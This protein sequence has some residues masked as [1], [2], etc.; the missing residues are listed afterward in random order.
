MVEDLPPQSPREAGCLAASG[1]FITL[2][3]GASIILIIIGNFLTT[4]YRPFAESEEITLRFLDAARSGNHSEMRSYLS[5]RGNHQLSDESLT[6]ISNFIQSNV[7]DVVRLSRTEEEIFIDNESGEEAVHVA[8]AVHGSIASATMKVT[9]HGPGGALRITS[10][11]L[12]EA[13]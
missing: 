6:A 3:V 9:L 11:T 1:A 10:I 4:Q 13:R 5:E 12:R 8:F 2:V 7:G